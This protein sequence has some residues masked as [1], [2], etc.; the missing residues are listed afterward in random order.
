MSWRWDAAELGNADFV[1]F[2][3]GKPAGLKHATPQVFSKPQ[4]K[5][6]KPAQGVEP[7][8]AQTRTMI[9]P[10]EKILADNALA[11]PGRRRVMTGV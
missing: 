11:P 5:D 2:Q 7:E 1:R 8:S 6:S 9:Y 4:K 10:P 3:I